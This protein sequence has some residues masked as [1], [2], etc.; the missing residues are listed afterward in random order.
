MV[1]L[2]LFLL[3]LPLAIIAILER[4][5]RDGADLVSDTPGEEPAAND[6]GL[7]VLAIEIAPL[8]FALAALVFH[9]S[10]LPLCFP[11]LAQTPITH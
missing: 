5:A 3:S 6:A 10:N 4:L 11:V 9:G 1:F 2:R 7:K 8:G